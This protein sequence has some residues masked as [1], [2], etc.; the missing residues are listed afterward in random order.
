MASLQF[1]DLLPREQRVLWAVYDYGGVLAD[2]QVQALFFPQSEQTIAKYSPEKRAKYGRTHRTVQL[3]LN[4]L[5]EWD[6]AEQPD[7]RHRMQ[8]PGYSVVWLTK[9]GAAFV[10]SMQGVSLASLKWRK[11]YSRWSE[12]EH[13]IEVSDFRIAV[14]RSAAPRSGF[15]LARWIGERDFLSHPDTVTYSV[16]D[17]KTTKTMRR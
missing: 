15:T 2:Y 1:R 10:A 14:E 7:F 16:P 11:P 12:T 5:K 3:V 6:Y 8:L 4:R 13:D 9:R 17:G